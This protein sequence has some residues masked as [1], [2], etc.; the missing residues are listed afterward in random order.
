MPTYCFKC[1]ACEEKTVEDRRIKR[2]NVI[3]KC[4]CGGMKRRDQ[5]T[6]FATSNIVAGKLP[7]WDTM[8]AGFM[9]SQIRAAQ[10]EYADL[11]V[12]IDKRG[13]A[14]VPG[15]NRDKFLKRRG[16]HQEQ[17]APTKNRQAKIITA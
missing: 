9:P 14:H 1:D 2:R 11:G 12:K 7:D 5:E 16:F 15:P 17:D 10:R 3:T 6:E 4:S 8:S 13:I